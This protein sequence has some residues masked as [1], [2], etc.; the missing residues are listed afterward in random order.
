MGKRNGIGGG[1]MAKKKRTMSAAQK[2]ALAK[3]RKALAAKRGGRQTVKRKSAP[4]AARKTAKRKTVAKGNPI[5]AKRRKARTGGGLKT[6]AR[7]AVGRARGF[8]GKSSGPMQVVKDAMLAVGGGIAAGVIA[9]KLPVADPRMKAAAPIAAGIALAA[10]LGRKNDMAKGF[11]TGMIVLGAVA[12]L[13]QLAPNI[14]MLAGEQEMMY[15]PQ[16]PYN[17]GLYGE[18]VDLGENDDLAY[19]GENVELGEE[20]VSPASL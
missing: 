16:L 18:T 2:A 15:V 1:D 5:M 12:L 3:G 19:M 8:F 10:T 6:R 20:Y 13:K 9:N 14:P 11:A 17:P 7:R 4:T